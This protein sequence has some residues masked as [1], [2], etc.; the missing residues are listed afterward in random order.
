MAKRVVQTSGVVAGT[1]T[2]RSTAPIQDPSAILDR[3]KDFPA[4]NVLTRRFNDPSDPG[5]APILLKDEAPDACTNTDHQTRLKPGA[6]TCHLCR[7]PARKWYVRYF[8]LAMEGRNSQMREKGYVPVELKELQSSDDVS[9]LFRSK[10]DTF[11]RRGDR[12]QELLAKT[13]LEA[14]LYVKRLQRDR[15]MA[16]SISAKQLRSDLA[17]AAGA[18]L[19]DEA[20]QTIHDGGILVESVTR[21]RTTLGAEAEVGEH[22]D[23]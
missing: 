9:D 17:E 13:P 11:V 23:E 21:S 3:F 12:G 18:E 15:R 5:S 7:R 8:N 2:R 6:T 4:I 10:D 19:G 16:D 22:D 1:K 20:G 14:L